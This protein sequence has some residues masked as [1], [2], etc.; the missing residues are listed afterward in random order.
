[1]EV[2]NCIE[3]IKN[4]PIENVLK[5]REN[6]FR[7]RKPDSKQSQAGNKYLKELAALEKE[8]SRTMKKPVLV[9]KL[10]EIDF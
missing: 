2:E 9:I 3:E 8:Y 1:M 5:R 4:E 6:Q 10:D 7:A